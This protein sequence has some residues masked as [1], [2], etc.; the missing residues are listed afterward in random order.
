MDRHRDNK[1]HVFSLSPFPLPIF[2]QPI[3]HAREKLVYTR[4]ILIRTRDKYAPSLSLSFSLVTFFFERQRLAGEKRRSDVP[5]GNEV[6]VRS[7]R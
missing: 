3:F 7:N 1:R 2:S 4:Q 6:T 5:F